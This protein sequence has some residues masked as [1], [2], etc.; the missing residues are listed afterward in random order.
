MGEELPLEI[1][2]YVPHRAGRHVRLVDIDSDC[3][4]QPRVSVRISFQAVSVADIEPRYVFFGRV[5]RDESSRLE[6]EITTKDGMRIEG[7]SLSC[8]QYSAELQTIESGRLYSVSVFTNTPLDFGGHS[9]MLCLDTDMGSRLEVP[10]FATVMGPLTYAPT[11]IVLPAD[12]E[13]SINRQVIV[14]AGTSESF[15][16]L[17]VGCPGTEMSAEVSPFGDD[18]YR[19]DI[20]NIVSRSEL[21]G[22]EISIRTDVEG[23]ERIT[24][25]ISLL[26]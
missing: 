8:A 6:V 21:D 26:K 1:A 2:F 12:R 9:A 23:M 15:K 25:P 4:E 22:R 19:V 24:I 18:G 14:R 7:A 5:E 16:I 3:P 17:G 13:D 10:V 20:T 11:Q